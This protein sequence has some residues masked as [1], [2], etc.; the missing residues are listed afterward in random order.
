MSEFYPYGYRGYPTGLKYPWI[1][2]SP[3]E[4]ERDRRLDAIRKSM[5]K[6]GFDCLIVG[7]AFAYMPSLHSELYYIS[8]FVPYANPGTYAV[9]PQKG[10]PWL[11][12]NNLLGPQ[13]LHIST[14]ASW[15]KDVMG[16]LRPAQDM[17]KKLKELK[18]E[19][20]KLGVM[21]YRQGSITAADYDT[22]RD[23]RGLRLNL[24]SSR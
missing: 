4:K 23:C 9:F 2:P 14:E 3:S 1:Y 7:A 21:G 24:T 19:K 16:S 18:L 10:E 17:V 11:V 5:K 6:H 15:I 8:N 22:L 13:F 20:G 12:V